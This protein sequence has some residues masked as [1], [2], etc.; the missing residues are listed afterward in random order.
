[1][2][3]QKSIPFARE[4]I[5]RLVLTNIFTSFHQLEMCSHRSVSEIEIYGNMICKG[6]GRAGERMQLHRN[7]DKIEMYSR[8]SVDH[9]KRSGYDV[10]EPVFV[11][12]LRPQAVV[13]DGELVVWNQRL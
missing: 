4:R 5:Y 13:L 1:M 6:W 12:Q 2:T 9:T 10:L 3:S 8:N 11:A 7:G